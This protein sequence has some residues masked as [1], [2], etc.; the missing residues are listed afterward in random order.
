MGQ[1][2]AKE[3]GNLHKVKVVEGLIRRL[4][5][6]HHNVE[7]GYRGRTVDIVISTCIS[8]N[9]TNTFPQ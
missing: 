5:S 1:L 8:S 6:S 7:K 4:W 9:I 3:Q 2:Q